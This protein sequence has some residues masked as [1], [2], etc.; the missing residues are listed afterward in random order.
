[1][2]RVQGSVESRSEL[3]RTG[4]RPDGQLQ[5]GKHT[6]ALRST[7]HKPRRKMRHLTM[8]LSS[9]HSLLLQMILLT[10]LNRVTEILYY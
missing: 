9:N 8:D 4:I 6:Y 5:V 3:K 10:R 2:T 1:M 7:R